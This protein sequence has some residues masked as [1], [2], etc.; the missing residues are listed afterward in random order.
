MEM[1]KQ[2]KKAQEEWKE[3]RDRPD[4]SFIKIQFL[5]HVRA[6]CQSRTKQLNFFI[7]LKD[8]VT[9]SILSASPQALFSYGWKSG[10]QEK[11]CPRLNFKSACERPLVLVQ[12]Y[13]SK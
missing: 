8:W 10:P 12:R 2:K 13:T 3:E 5:K 6:E 1:R 11:S 4:A 7:C 9:F